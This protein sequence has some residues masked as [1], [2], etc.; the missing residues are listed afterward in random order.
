[1]LSECIGLTVLKFR[2]NLV[3][4]YYDIILAGGGAAGLSLAYHLSLSSVA[5]KKILIIDKDRKEKNDRTW[6]FWSKRK[7]A[8]DHLASLTYHSLVFSS[9]YYEKRIDLGKYRYQV[10]RGIDFYDFIR[11]H[12][13]KYPE[14]HWL[15]TKVESMN[16]LPEGAEVVTG[17]GTYRSKWVFSSIFSEADIKNAI[18]TELYLKQHF[19]GYVIETHE[20]A[21][22]PDAFTMFDF[23][24]PQKGLMRFF[25]TLPWSKNKALV[26]YTL[27]SEDLLEEGQY[28][29]A[30]REYI[31][32]VLQINDYQ[33]AEKEFGIIPMTNYVFPH[34]QGKHIINI[35][36]AGGASKP[37]SGY[38]FMR[39]QKHVQKITE[40]LEKNIYPGMNGNSPP[41]YRFY[42]SVLLN[43]LKNNGHLSEWIFSKM[44]Q[45]NTIRQVFQ[46]LDEEGGLANDLKI[47]TSLPPWP[48]LRSTIQLILKNKI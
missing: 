41:R 5:G 34:T 25:Y 8:F 38:T 10:I 35:G 21:F 13:A 22:D 32:E 42:D 36:S 46:F 43:I 31:S 28:D 29:E 30:I 11:D 37:S 44:F 12:L 16:N 17:E 27:F 45:N 48:F 40:A 4:G 39:I 26:E 23:H 3:K 2:N 15:N 14:V 18:K 20:D 19:K 6:G 9:T 24:T 33:I 7:T 47:I 1:M